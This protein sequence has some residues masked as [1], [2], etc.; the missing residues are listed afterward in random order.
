M[1]S[2]SPNLTLMARQ[3]DEYEYTDEKTRDDRG[4]HQTAVH[5]SCD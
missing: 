4:G 5:Y 2:S 3:E 1:R